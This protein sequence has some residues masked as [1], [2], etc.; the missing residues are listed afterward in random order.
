[1]NKRTRNI[2]IA[3]VVLL[4]LVGAYFLITA[5]TREDSSDD[6]STPLSG[7]SETD[8]E[9]IEYTKNAQTVTLIKK[10]GEWKYAEDEGFPL[11]TE[12]VDAMAKQI[13]E[14]SATRTLS[15]AKEL[16]IYG[17]SEP[18]MTISAK[19]ADSKTLKF[20]VGDENS[21]SDGCYVKIEGD[22]NVYL[23]SSSLTT[24]F[25]YDL[26][27]L[28][29]AGSLPENITDS[30]ALSLTIENADGKYAFTTPV[31]LGSYYA[32]YKW[33]VAAPSGD[34]L[35]DSDAVNN[36]ISEIEA[37]DLVN[38]AAYDASDD[39]LSKL[40]FDDAIHVELTYKYEEKQEDEDSDA[41]PVY[42]QSALKLDI[43]KKDD[44]TYL[45]HIDGEKNVYSIASYSINGLLNLSEEKLAVTDVCALDYD[46]VDGMTVEYDGQKH[47]VAISR[48]GDEKT[49]ALDKK[50]IGEVYI[51][52]FF[53]DLIDL[54]S[55]GTSEKSGGDVLLKVTFKR[56]TSDEFSEM[57]LTISKYD[58]AFAL[59]SFAGRENLINL[60]DA[61]S[62]I[63]EFDGLFKLAE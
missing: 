2:I 61:D 12:K 27:G 46:S 3:L 37:L 20:T 9:Q 49:A 60:R 53:E 29:A 21:L 6:A 33:Q 51:N 8:I 10:D 14:L 59:A 35:A 43:A 58:S 45:L 11:N 34:M 62:L 13:A 19:S 16:S 24:A 1:M 26:M 63:S 17:L 7:M 23:V 47:T 44:D 28:G 15:D 41:D 30:E 22:D 38:L 42:K 57:T 40:G 18:Q 55:E 32:G 4:L 25:A 31:T 50:S 52:G 56:N 39:E 5:L 48:D 54:E 36:I